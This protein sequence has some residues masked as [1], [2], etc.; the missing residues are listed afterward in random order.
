MIV[1]S[2]RRIK[3]FRWFC[4]TNI[5]AY[6]HKSKSTF[7]KSFVSHGVSISSD[8]CIEQ[9]CLMIWYC[10]T[11]IFPRGKYSLIWQNIAFVKLHFMLYMK[12][13]WVMRLT[14]SNFWGFKF[15]CLIL[16]VFLFRLILHFRLVF[17]FSTFP[18]YCK[19]QALFKGERLFRLQH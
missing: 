3:L 1:T 12:H 18:S 10:F 4:T 6:D 7:Q 8:M 19:S 2:R 14:A 16:P 15:H 9:V 17:P 13:V 5:E 11:Y